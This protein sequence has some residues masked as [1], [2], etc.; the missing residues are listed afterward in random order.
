MPAITGGLA[1]CGKCG[2]DVQPAMARCRNCGQVLV[3]FRLKLSESD[4]DCAAAAENARPLRESDDRPSLVDSLGT[5]HL[6]DLLNEAAVADHVDNVPAASRPQTAAARETA[7]ARA[8]DADTASGI[9]SLTPVPPNRRRPAQTAE[10]GQAAADGNSPDDK[11]DGRVHTTC[12]QCGRDVRG[13]KSL[14]GKAVKCPTCGESVRLPGG[15]GGATDEP[16]GGVQRLERPAARALLL[17]VIDHAIG[18]PPQAAAA[19]RPQTLKSRELRQARKALEKI[20]DPA[21]RSDRELDSARDALQRLVDSGDPRA[22]E[23][24]IPQLA[25]LPEALQCFALRGIGE[26]QAAEG[27][28]VVLRSLV[29]G[30]E[31]VAAS[32]VYA[33]GRMQDPR[34]ATPLAVVAAGYTE[35]RSRALDALTEVGAGA[36]AALN[37]LCAPEHPAA[38]REVAAEAFG[39]IKDHRAAQPLSRLQKD[40]DPGVRRAAVVALGA[41][42]HRSAL[43]PLVA[44]LSDPDEQVRL[45]AVRALGENPDPRA[46]PYLSKL[47]KSPVREIQLECLHALGLCAEAERARDLQPFLNCGDEELELAAVEAVARLG[48]RTALPRLL[49]MLDQATGTETDERWACRIV[50]ALRRLKDARA[51]LPLIELLNCRADRV[52]TRAAEALGAIGDPTALE[53][54]ADR[55]DQEPSLP[56]QAALIK[57]LG[58]LKDPAALPVLRRAIEKSDPVRCKAIAALGE[59]GGPEAVRL[60]TDQLDH[61]S[62]PVR[63]QAVTALGRIGSPTTVTHL[64]PLA[65]DPDEMVRRA[66]IKSIKDLGDER[67]ESDFQTQL[68]R[69]KSAP[70]AR[71][72]RTSMK[73]PSFSGRDWRGL[74]PDAVLGLATGRQLA[75][76]GGG[77]A[78][79]ICVVVAFVVGSPFSGGGDQVVP[80]GFVESLSFSADGGTLAAGR[81]FGRIEMWN[82]DAATLDRT[83]QFV[84][85]K[86]V[87]QDG[88]GRYL[89]AGDENRS[90]LYEVESGKLIVEEKGIKSLTVNRAQSRAA[91]EAV[92]GRLIVWNLETGRIDAALEF[93]GSNTTAFAVSPDG[94]TCVVGTSDGSLIVID[95]QALEVLYQHDVPEA[96]AVTGLGFNADGS[97]IAVGTNKGAIHLW[98]LESDVPQASLASTSP[99]RIASV[100]FLDE[101][102]LVAL[103]GLS[104][105][106]WDIAAAAATEIPISL[107]SADAFAVDRNAGRCAVGSSEES[108]IL[109]YDLQ[110]GQR[111]AELDIAA[112]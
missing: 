26:L 83:L 74:I 54:L 27:L 79:T 80:R 38:L 81:G 92:D 11:D 51:V 85:G 75:A 90:G 10:A 20:S 46:A 6:D 30:I 70:K 99:E 108:A 3:D 50:D 31:P 68:S 49:E 102:R 37:Q 40:D 14:A 4:V 64:E 48:D 82:I 93:D 8:S 55:F 15:D 67:S 18:L 110:S 52:R 88:A 34:A 24:I 1:Q 91:S 13:P 7:A 53:P 41:L 2:A 12:G 58:E 36:L 23:V 9:E 69:V 63:Y 97:Q 106:T 89:V 77:L 96:A 98:P 29:D 94:G 17:K 105:D 101:H 33:L 28:A 22:A 95:M 100:A 42:G 76:I 56:A 66:A 5:F 35:Q 73:L 32:A 19:D 43:K 111:L 61:R 103:R 39:R 16:R 78:A 86:R 44:A 112:D 87:A 84:N 107:E 21:K 71:R 47:L 65:R 62:A 104:I 72:P 109:V 57:S 25:G 59:I 60:V 45:A